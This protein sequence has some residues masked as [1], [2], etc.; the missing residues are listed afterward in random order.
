MAS[1]RN[2]S[3]LFAT[4]PDRAP[5]KC[6]NLEQ[7]KID[8]SGPS[9]LDMQTAAW[10]R[11]ARRRFGPQGRI[12]APPMMNSVMPTSLP[13]GRNSFADVAARE[14]AMQMRAAMARRYSQQAQRGAAGHQQWPMAIQI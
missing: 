5:V 1:M 3:R 6:S 9:M 14:T 12:T 4:E 11:P 2:I 10:Q 7:L 8:V 13:E